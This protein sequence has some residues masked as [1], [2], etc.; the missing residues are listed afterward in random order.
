MAAG[1][2]DHCLQA[3]SRDGTLCYLFVKNFPVVLL[4]S[5]KANDLRARK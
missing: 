3:L 4:D 2:V 5:N 1:A